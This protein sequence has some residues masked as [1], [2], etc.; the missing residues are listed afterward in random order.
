MLGHQGM[1]AQHF[2]DR[3]KVALSN[4]AD[5][6]NPGKGHVRLNFGTS[7]EVLNEILGRLAGARL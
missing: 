4:G 7:A 6:G 1:D 5:F 3:A 2:L